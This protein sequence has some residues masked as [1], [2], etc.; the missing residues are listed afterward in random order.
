MELVS[1]GTKGKHNTLPVLKESGS[2]NSGSAPFPHS[3]ARAV[4]AL[5]EL[6]I[7]EAVQ[8]LTLGFLFLLRVIEFISDSG[9]RSSPDIL[10]TIPGEFIACK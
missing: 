5:W 10:E 6:G 9:M 7:R 2:L 3:T 8:M 1:S 4:I